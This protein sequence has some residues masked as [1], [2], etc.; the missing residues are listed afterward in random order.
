[1][2]AANVSMLLYKRSTLA[3]IPCGRRRQPAQRLALF[4]RG[5][6]RPSNRARKALPSITPGFILKTTMRPE[7]K[8]DAT[9][10]PARA[11][12]PPVA[13]PAGPVDRSAA[14]EAWFARRGWTIFPF[15]RETWRLMS[16]GRSGLLHA[17]TGSG[18]TLAVAFGAWLAAPE[19]ADADDAIRVLW[20][21]PMRALA[22]DTERSLREAFGGIAG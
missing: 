4:I 11:L 10:G 2:A 8:D 3:P 19:T 5:P 1:M 21:T 22:A 6:A 18:K 12:V 14:V 7:E 15:Q 17:T 9:V 13:P 20:V 16:E